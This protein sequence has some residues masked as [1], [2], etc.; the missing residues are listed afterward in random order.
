MGIQ[1]T[2]FLTRRDAEVKYVAKREEEMRRKLLSEA[3]AMSDE[4]LESAIE[5]TFDNYR[6]VDSDEEARE[7]NALW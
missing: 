1:S 6:I 7:R 5:S 4:E 3:V 2:T